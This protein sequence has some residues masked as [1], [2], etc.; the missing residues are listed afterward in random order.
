MQFNI[1]QLDKNDSNVVVELW[2]K[3]SIEAH[4]FIPTEYWR[5]NKKKMADEYLPNSETYGAFCDG[6]IM[7][8]VSM[9]DSYLAAL[10]VDSSA[11]GQGI[12]TKLLD[13]VKNLR[14]KIQLKVYKK[15]DNSV[16]FYENKG[17]RII[18]ENIDQETGEIEYLMLWENSNKII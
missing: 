2:Y 11:Q 18:S 4:D 8:F 5:S 15:N 12:G 10:F 6:K 3:L 1:K 9:L 13:Y 7:G 17:F 16:R 14:D